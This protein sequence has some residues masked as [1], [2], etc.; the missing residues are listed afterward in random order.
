MEVCHWHVD[1]DLRSRGLFVHD[2]GRVRVAAGDAEEGTINGG[3]RPLSFVIDTELYTSFIQTSEL[4]P[5]IQ[6]D[7]II[8]LLGPPTFLFSP[9]FLACSQQQIR[10]RLGRTN[11]PADVVWNSLLFF[12]VLCWE[13]SPNHPIRPGVT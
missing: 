7:E 2:G 6:Q 4:S 12:T 3:P 13:I 9:F 10:A 11:E 1:I 5:L 8:C